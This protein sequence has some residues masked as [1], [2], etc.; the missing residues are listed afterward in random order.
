MI[1][2]SMCVISI[3]FVNT[4]TAS[5]SSS[6]KWG[7]V[8]FLPHLVKSMYC[9]LTLSRVVFTLHSKGRATTSAAPKTLRKV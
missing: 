8:M 4:I 5:V 1:E 3:T 7:R 2:M 6:D 9:L